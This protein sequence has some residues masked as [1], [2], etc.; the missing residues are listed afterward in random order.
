MKL[1]QKPLQP[2]YQVCRVCGYDRNENN[3]THCEACKLSLKR[4]TISG[5]IADVPALLRGLQHSITTW[6]IL[7]QQKK[8]I[9]PISYP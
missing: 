9:S 4:R 1:T 2:Q 6:H 3:A 7:I 8:P 5:A